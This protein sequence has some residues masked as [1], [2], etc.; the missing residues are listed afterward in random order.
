MRSTIICVDDEKLLLNVLYEQ[1]ETWFGKKYTIEKASN[2]TE[3]LKI[4]DDCLAQG[5]NVSVFISDY[6]MPIMK[7]DELLTLVK[8][9]D[10][11]IKRIMLTGYS[12][13]DGIVNAINKA[14]IYR[15]ISK[16]WDN[17]DLMLTLLEAIKSYEQDKITAELTKNYETLYH[18][19][20]TLYNETDGNYDNLLQSFAL[21]CD[22]R[23][24][25]KPEHSERVA[26]YAEIIADAINLDD[27]TKKDLR[28]A[29]YLHDVGKLAMTDDELQNLKSAKKYS[30][31]FLQMRSYQANFSE[32]IIELLKSPTNTID[33]VK[34]QFETYDGKGPFGLKGE[35]IPVGARIIH[36][37]NLFDVVSSRMRN[38]ALKDVLVEFLTQG[39]T[40]LD[41]KLASLFVEQMKKIKS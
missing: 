32:R 24:Q 18:K 16:P 10:P 29:A 37:A 22:L 9:K 11:K 33:F 28:Q 20:E 2:A 14:G 26:Q 40:Y 36:I 13:I 38:S 4:L 17:K 7:G 23:D 39:K 30:A 19:Y 12:A 25:A 8:E 41:T 21:A 31:E 1:L 27:I 34:Y 6:I 3:A 5:R 35:E 15:Y